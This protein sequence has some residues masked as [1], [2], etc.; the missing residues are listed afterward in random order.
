MQDV[1]WECEVLTQ[2]L[3][4]RKVFNYDLPYKYVRCLEIRMVQKS[5]YLVSGKGGRFYNQRSG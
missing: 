4:S 5:I 2:K 3:L 1:E